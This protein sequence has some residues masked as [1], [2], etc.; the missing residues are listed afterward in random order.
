VGTLIQDH[1]GSEIE[2][3]SDAALAVRA[4]ESTSGDR[5]AF[6]HLYDRH[7]PAV[8]GY[9]R[10]LLHDPA[11]VEDVLQETFVRVYTRLGTYDPKR[12]FR[13]WLLRV[14]RNAALDVLRVEGK[15]RRVEAHQS[16]PAAGDDPSAA[17]SRTEGVERLR[18]A[19]GSLPPAERAL[20]VERHGA[21]L[22]LTE[23]ADSYGVTE[24]TVRNRLRRAAGLLARALVTTRPLPPGADQ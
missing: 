14:A 5:A 24:R 15:A 9:L 3:L 21:C 8:H 20:L 16:P 18:A 11:R 1:V 12:P 7:R 2:R 4:R 22:K 6:R 19:L 23:L 10:R 17:A 13:P